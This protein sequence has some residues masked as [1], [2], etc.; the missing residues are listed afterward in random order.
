[1]KSINI[2]TNVLQNTVEKL[3]EK[4]LNIS[5]IFDDIEKKMHL[6]DGTSDTW[7]SN[8]QASVYRNYRTISDNFPAMVGQLNGYVLFLKKTIDN[9]KRGESTINNSIENNQNNLKIN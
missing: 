5:N 7:R 9:Y 1:M 8:A 3:E 2:E 4:V 6:I